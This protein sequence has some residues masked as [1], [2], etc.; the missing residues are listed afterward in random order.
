[1]YS[2]VIIPPEPLYSQLKKVIDELAKEFDGPIFEPHMTLLGN[3]EM[4]LGQLKEKLNVLSQINKLDLKLGEVSLSTTYFQNVFIRV[5]P[6][7]QFLEL[8]INAKNLFGIENNVFMPHISLLY[9]NQDMKKREEAA[10]KIN[11][12]QASFTADRFIII[13]VTP[14]PGQWVHVLEVRFKGLLD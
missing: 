2:I 4:D 8:N 11:I 10:S 1:M 5:N 14:D 13:P 7:H 6:T 3:I 12:A 9:G